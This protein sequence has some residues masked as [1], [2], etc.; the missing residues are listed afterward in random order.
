[1]F[2][3]IISSFIFYRIRSIRD[4]DTQEV[5]NNFEDY[6]Q[7]WLLESL[8][9]VTLGKQLGLLRDHS[10]NYEDALKLFTS[11]NTIFTVAFDLEWK[12]SLWRRVRTPKFRRFLQAAD[13]MQAIT[14]KY[15]DEAITNLEA[16]KKMGIVRLEN[17]MSAFERLLKIDKKIATVMC[18]DLFLAGINT[19]N[20]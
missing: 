12:P 9:I 20:I 17:E 14:L 1:M 16:E 6:L 19:V 18:I 7:C 5:P 8:S 10:E 2:S 3:I 13:N 15:I 4:R 11:L